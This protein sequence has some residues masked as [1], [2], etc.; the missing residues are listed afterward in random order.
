MNTDNQPL[1]TT[2]P[3]AIY[4]PTP[5]RQHTVSIALPT[6]LL[7]NSK[8]KLDLR[9]H[10]AG[11]ISRALAVFSIDEIVLYDDGDDH[12]PDTNKTSSYHSNSQPGPN[13]T[14]L[15]A[16]SNPSHFLRYILTYQE[17]PPFMRNRLFPMHENLS[18]A[19][20]L[21]SL[22]IPS[23]LKSDEWCPYR[24]GVTVRT[25]REGTY[26]DCGVPGGDY[27]VRDVQIAPKARVT[28]RMGM[29]SEE[30]DVEVVSPSIPRE[31]GGYYWG[32]TIREAGSL[33]AVFTE[34]SFDGG[35]DLSV[36]TS[37]RGE[38]VGG[39]VE[40]LLDE[41]RQ[42]MHMIIVFGG[43]KGLEEAA[44]ADEELKRMGIS[45][46]NVSELFDFWVNLVPGQGSRTIRTEEAVWIGLMG[47][48]SVVEE[49]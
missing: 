3:T 47:I 40:R 22:D 39:V 30:L 38:A 11:S 41:E 45:K 24:E 7:A 25:A 5:P 1:D 35:Y 14:K 10:L 37:E 48:R 44:A 2:R 13:N 9:T 27:L 15:T 33:S 19:G 34:C 12:E 4:T 17:T 43:V 26:V 6:S 31:E 18:Q 28:V 32:Y 20:L 16:F 36:G 29:D 21:P 23:H 46:G 8:R 49:R 42:W